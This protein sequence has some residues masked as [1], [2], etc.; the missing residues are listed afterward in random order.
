[1]T[2]FITVTV[3]ALAALILAL[4]AGVFLSFSDFIMRS[5]CAATPTSGIEAMQQINRK[6]YSSVFLVWLLGMA[7]VATLLSLYAFVFVEGPA[8][9][10]WI[11]GGALY[12]IGTF[13][14]TVLG[15]VPMNKRLDPITPD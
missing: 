12:V 8:K 6:V 14:V 11:A 13:L 9:A 15:N 2:S 1:M 3:Y 7:P 5:L 4:I 10:W